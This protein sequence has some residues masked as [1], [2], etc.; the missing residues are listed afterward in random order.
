ML[1]CHDNAANIDDLFSKYYLFN[2][3]LF[4][5]HKTYHQILP[6][7]FQE[8]TLMLLTSD[9]TFYDLPSLNFKIPDKPITTVYKIRMNIQFTLTSS[10]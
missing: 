7:P 5:Y 1:I 10:R 8:Y 6:E 2:K 4:D 3:I 9:I